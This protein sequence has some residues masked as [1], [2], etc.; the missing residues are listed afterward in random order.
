MSCEW[1]I[2]IQAL[3]DGE[4]PLDE[5]AAVEAHAVSCPECAAQLQSLGRMARFLRAPVIPAMNELSV[6]R[7]NKN[8]G[9]RIAAERL[10]GRRTARLAGWLTAAA[11]VVLT[12]CTVGLY[13]MSDMSGQVRPAGTE[14]WEQ[15]ATTLELP[16]GSD[17]EDPTVLIV[18]VDT[19]E[20]P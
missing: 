11:A 8:L 20:L 19:D 2:K 17:V 14:G 16:T 1:D 4:L 12:A 9:E 18:D 10:N 3:H 5:R 7:I 13:S 15:V 6:A